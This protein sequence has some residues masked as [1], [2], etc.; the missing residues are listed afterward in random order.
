MTAFPSDFAALPT[1]SFVIP[2]LDHDMHDGTVA[3]G[4]SWLQQPSRRICRWAKPT[5]AC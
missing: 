5:T 1:V 4:D 2:N 3:A